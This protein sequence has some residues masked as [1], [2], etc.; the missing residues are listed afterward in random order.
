MRIHWLYEAI[1]RHLSFC[2]LN[3]SVTSGKLMLTGNIL[4]EF[5]HDS[6]ILPERNFVCGV[7]QITRVKLPSPSPS[8][9]SINE[10]MTIFF[11]FFPVF[12]LVLLYANSPV[13]HSLQADLSLIFCRGWNWILLLLVQPVRAMRAAQFYHDWTVYSVCDVIQILS[14][15]CTVA[16]A[17]G[18]SKPVVW[19]LTLYILKINVSFI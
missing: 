18:T 12:L 2:S 19:C 15:L 5:W 4:Q 14:A 16:H 10:H 17:T 8:P 6:V 9:K 11:F 13:A 3:L 7:S 1:D